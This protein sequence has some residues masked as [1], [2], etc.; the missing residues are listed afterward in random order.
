MNGIQTVDG[1][2]RN[3]QNQ[4]S[5]P[6]YGYQQLQVVLNPDAIASPADPIPTK[7][8]AQ[9]GSSIGVFRVTPWTFGPDSTTDDAIYCSIGDQSSF[10]QGIPIFGLGSVASLNIAKFKRLNI[11]IGGQRPMDPPR[12]NTGKVFLT[13]ETTRG[14]S[15]ARTPLTGL[16]PTGVGL[17]P[18]A[19][20]SNNTASSNNG[21]GQVNYIWPSRPFRVILAGA[22]VATLKLGAGQL[23]QLRVDNGLNL[24]DTFIELF[25]TVLAPVLG[26]DTPVQSW[27]APAGSIENCLIPA[28]GINFVNNIRMVAVTADLGAVAPVSNVRTIGAIL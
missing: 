20:N 6:E 14:I 28:G 22:A 7:L 13:L 21:T 9:S 19:V 15:I 11:W 17:A 5:L 25:D 26:V 16:L 4:E 24:V 10:M 3:A 8:Q 1:L 27:R 23:T 2:L 12:F 18:Q